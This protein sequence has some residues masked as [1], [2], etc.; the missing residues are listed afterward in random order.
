MFRGSYFRK[1]TIIL[2]KSALLGLIVAL[3]MLFTA[4]PASA[5]GISLYIDGW[6][7]TTDVS[8]T[9]VNDRVM[10]PIRFIAEGLGAEVQWQDPNIVIV[11]DDFK[12]QLIV[13]SKTVYKNGILTGEMDTVPFLKE[14]RTMVPLRFIAEALNVDVNYNDSKV[15]FITPSFKEKK[16][17]YFDLG[18]KMRFDYLPEVSQ[19]K[20][21]NLASFLMY[22]FFRQDDY[23]HY[24]EMSKEYVEE[25][26][27]DNFAMGNI[28]HA[29][30]KEWEFDG[31][32]YTPTGWSYNNNCFCELIKENTYQ[33]NDKTI[34]EVVLDNYSFYEYAFCSL[35]FTPD[36]EETYSDPMMY[37]LKEKGDEIRNGM[38]AI[39]AIKALIVEGDTANFTKGETLRI[40]YYVDKASS[41]IVFTHVDNSKIQN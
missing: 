18:L 17:Y 15:L 19:D 8:P 21:P 13:D 20:D 28:S 26:A 22:A 1:T 4:M 32:I 33:E 3:G 23:L 29:S 27:R 14:N 34:Y 37:V 41:N 25:L 11:K 30:T 16:A 38:S 6:E 10:A 40:K 7:V 2:K 35:D 24:D 9:L 5:G 12:L 31:D 39:D 36:F